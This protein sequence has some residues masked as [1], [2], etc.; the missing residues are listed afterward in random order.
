MMSLDSSV[1]I[2]MGYRMG[3]QDILLFSAAPRLVL[4]LTQPPNQQLPG[5]LPLGFKQPRHEADH[6]PPSSAGI[7]SGAISPTFRMSSRCGA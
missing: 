7:K 3:D 6:S 5:T 1:G 2:V 4:G